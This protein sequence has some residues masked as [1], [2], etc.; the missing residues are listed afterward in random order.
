M[1]S[2]LARASATSS[3]SRA[4]DPG[5]SRRSTVSLTM[6]PSLTRP[7]SMMRAMRLT[8][9]L[10]PPSRSTQ[11]LP[12]RPTRLLTSAARA[13]APAPS[14]TVFSISRRRRMALAISSSLT[15]TTSSTKRRASASVWRPTRRTAMPSAMVA[16]AGTVTRSPAWRAARIPGISSLC[17]PVTRTAGLSALRATATPPMSPPPPTGTMTAS[18][19]GTCSA[20][21]RAIVPCPAMTRGSSKGWMNTRPR[22]TSIS[23]A[24][25]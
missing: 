2:T 11:V 12:S 18:R 21:S 6:R 13:T 10:P 15:V 25:A 23:R 9:M 7:R 19:S 4:S 1:W 5:L 8:S 24:R 14:T 22:S 3:V 20:S 16:A 17:T